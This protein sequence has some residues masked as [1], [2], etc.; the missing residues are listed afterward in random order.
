MRRPGTPDA[1]NAN[2]CYFYLRDLQGHGTGREGSA[3]MSDMTIHDVPDDLRVWIREKARSH[4][5]SVSRELLELLASM[6]SGLEGGE[7]FVAKLARIEELC[8]HC[9]DASWLDAGDTGKS[10]V[11][12]PY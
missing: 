11:G 8:R 10:S 4:H 12:H 3:E 2:P 1:R 9:A 7:S 6:H 5:Q